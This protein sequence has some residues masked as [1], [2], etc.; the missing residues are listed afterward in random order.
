LDAS[1]LG[2]YYYYTSYALASSAYNLEN[3]RVGYKKR[4]WTTSLWIRNLFNAHYAQQGFYFGVIPPNF[5]NQSFLQ[6]GDP[7]QVG[8]TVDYALGQ[9]TEVR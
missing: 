8:I 9:R 5:P 6:W 3:L 4:G 1:A 2:S 7:R